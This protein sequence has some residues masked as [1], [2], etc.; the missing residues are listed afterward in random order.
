MKFFLRNAPKETPGYE[1]RNSTEPLIVPK[2]VK[3]EDYL[4]V[5]INIHG[6][7]RINRPKKL[8]K[9]LNY[10]F[11]E[12]DFE[13]RLE[14]STTTLR[15]VRGT[16]RKSWTGLVLNFNA[17]TEQFIVQEYTRL[18]SEFKKPEP[19][20]DR[21]C[22][23]SLMNAII[24]ANQVKEFTEASAEDIVTIMKM[25]I[26]LVEAIIR[27]VQRH[28]HSARKVDAQKVKTIQDT[29]LLANILKS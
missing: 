23:K 18:R 15:K 17:E 27:G 19:K 25:D 16:T 12:G 26:E 5:E 1:E 22:A 28:R 10:V 21:V 13:F 8:P 11:N 6:L 20:F 9:A 14:G 24:E 29:V 2:G 7:R 3:E 4:E